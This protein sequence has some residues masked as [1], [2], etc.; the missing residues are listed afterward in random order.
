MSDERILL[1]TGIPSAAFNGEYLYQLFGEYGG[2]QQIRLG[3]D[4]L[5]KGCAIVVY[6]L[7]DSA[8]AAISALDGFSVSKGRV[9]RLCVYDEKR[10][11]RGL[12]RRK[13]KREAHAEY[14]ENIKNS[15]N[16]GEEEV[17]V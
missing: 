4:S 14:R 15:L 2:I 7:C 10:D 17:D 8:A 12:E 6:E 1:V 9:L 13:R 5:T 16:K 11:K 3:S